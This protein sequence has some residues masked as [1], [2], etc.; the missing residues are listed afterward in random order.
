MVLMINMIP[1]SPMGWSSRNFYAIG[2]G[3][4][5]RRHLAGAERT[6][7]KRPRPVGRLGGVVTSGSSEGMKRIW[8]WLRVIHTFFWHS[9]WHTIWSSYYYYYYLSFKWHYM[10]YIYICRVWH[11][12]WHCVWHRDSFWHPGF[13][14]F[15]KIDHHLFGFG[16]WIKAPM[17]V[18]L[19]IGY[20]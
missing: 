7:L 6:A 10:I 20:P 19:K 11:S 1:I 15:V 13:G 3:G 17:M 4:E 16:F 18:C 14:S 8:K 12:F 2:Q 5:T 9:F